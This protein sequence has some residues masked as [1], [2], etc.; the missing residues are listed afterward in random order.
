MALRSYRW[1]KLWSDL[2]AEG[3]DGFKVGVPSHR[4]PGPI[5]FDS[6]CDLCDSLINKNVWKPDKEVCSTCKEN[7]QRVKSVIVSLNKLTKA[8]KL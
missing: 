6:H 3:F 5:F 2:K 1:D 7:L 4:S 8:Y